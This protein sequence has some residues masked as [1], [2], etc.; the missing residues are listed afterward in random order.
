[1]PHH[2][3]LWHGRKDA[4]G[5]RA[6]QVSAATGSPLQLPAAIGNGP[7]LIVF[8]EVVNIMAPRCR[9]DPRPGAF[10]RPGYM[11]RPP[12][13]TG[14]AHAVIV[15]AVATTLP[16]THRF[17]AG[18]LARIEAHGAFSRIPGGT[19]RGCVEKTLDK[20]PPESIKCRIDQGDGPDSF[21]TRGVPLTRLKGW[22]L[23]WVFREGRP[24]GS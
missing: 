22:R 16:L 2:L 6:L 7:N 14:H 24:D 1:V 3:C 9:G 10:G 5:T 21:M 19:R 4:P 17:G 11:H 8:A 13:G 20:A 12:G 23:H 15:P 18:T